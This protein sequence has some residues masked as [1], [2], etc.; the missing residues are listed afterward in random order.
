VAKVYR[1]FFAS[2]PDRFRW[3]REGT[4][5]NFWLNCT[6]CENI[7]ERNEFLKYT[8]EEGVMTRPMWQLLNRLP[9]YKSCETDALTHSNFLAERLVNI[10][11]SVP[12]LEI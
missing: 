11:S 6:V 3:E 1:D 9:M 10:P 4:R 7:E 2:S 5:A 12:S 8:N